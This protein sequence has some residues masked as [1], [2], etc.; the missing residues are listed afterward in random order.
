M[1]PKRTSELEDK[2]RENTQK[3][4][5]RDLKDRN[6]KREIAGCPGKKQRILIIAINPC[7]MYTGTNLLED[8]MANV[9]IMLFK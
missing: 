4:A 7:G 8:N 6:Y 1:T 3:V 9:H 5:H 2:S